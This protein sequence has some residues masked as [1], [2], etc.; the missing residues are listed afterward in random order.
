MLK[1]GGA[2]G[3]NC[4]FTSTFCTVIHHSLIIF[5]LSF[6]AAHKDSDK[7]VRYLAVDTHS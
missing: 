6:N 7:S 3:N 4:S 1:P 5:E 2:Y